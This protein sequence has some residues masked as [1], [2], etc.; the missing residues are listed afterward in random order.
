MTTA[1]SRTVLS[2]ATRRWYLK[3]KTS[4]RDLPLGQ[5]SQG[6]GGIGRGNGEA[7]V[8][9]GEVALKNHAR[10]L[11]G[12]GP[13][14]PELAGQAVLEGAPQAFHPSLGLRGAGSDPARAQL[15]EEAPDLGRSAAAGELLL[16]GGGL[17]DR[18]EDRVLVAVYG[19]GDA[20]A[21]HHLP[22]QLEVALGILLLPE[23]GPGNQ[24]GGVV[25]A[26]DQGE[27]GPST[28]QPVVAAAV[29]LEQHALA[30]IAV[31]TLSM[32]GWPPVANAGDPATDRMRCTVGRER[33][34]P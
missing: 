1:P 15:L 31:P 22:E 17:L 34:M 8:V 23:A 30:R 24:A 4:W 21:A 29:D 28:L 32:P 14:E 18:V 12:R 10:L 27:V 5:G 2:L 13:G 16:Q 11:L 33:T 3:Q 6:G 25:D 26:A 7:A 20:T 9:P 19:H